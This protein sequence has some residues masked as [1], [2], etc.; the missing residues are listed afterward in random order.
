[1]YKTVRKGDASLQY[2][3]LPQ[4]DQFTSGGFPQ[5]SGK[6]QLRVTKYAIGAL[7][8]LITMSCV[9]T[10]FL[11]HQNDHNLFADTTLAMSRVEP[12]RNASRSVQTKEP[13]ASNKNRGRIPIT[14]TV[15]TTEVT[16]RKDLDDTTTSFGGILRGEEEE[17][18]MMVVVDDATLADVPETNTQRPP[19]TSETSTNVHQSATTSSSSTLLPPTTTTTSASSSA[20]PTTSRTSSSSTTKSTTVSSTA[21]KPKMPRVTLKLRENETIPQMFMKAGIASYK[22][23]NITTSVLAHG[24][25]LEG[26]IFKTPEGTIKPWPQK[27]FFSD[28]SA[29]FQ[30]KGPIQIPMLLYVLFAGLAALA[31]AVVFLI[32][33]AQRKVSKRQRRD[34]EEPEVEEHE[35]DKSTL[36]GVESQE[37]EEKE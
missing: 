16:K 33:H 30:W 32:F 23:G 9:A 11:M 21:R 18:A 12:V 37:T 13:V 26:L 35:E 3:I 15:S 1:M 6:T 4:T 19:S 24:L 17:E 8:V 2:T 22:K 31:S 14:T 25:S 10:P 27:W 36:L 7:M 20:F 5:T 34:I 28:P 29:D